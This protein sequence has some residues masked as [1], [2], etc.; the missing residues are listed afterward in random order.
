MIKDSSVL[1][2]IRPITNLSDL[3]FQ[4][5]E[6]RTK[7]LQERLRRMLEVLQEQHSAG[8]PTDVKKMKQFLQEQEE[9]LAITNKEIIEA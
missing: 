2:T 1:T 9:W 6:Y 7:V 4:W 8:K 5:T 3:Y